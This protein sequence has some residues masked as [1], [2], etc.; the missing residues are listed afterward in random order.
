MD[1]W[2]AH[3]MRRRACVECTHGI[4]PGDRVAIGQWKRTYPWGTRT[5]RVV[6]HWKCWLVKQEIW[7][8]EHPYT[9]VIQ[10]GPGRPVKYTPEQR[11][12]RASLR[13]MINQNKK[14]QVEYIGDDMWATAERY[15][16]KIRVYRDELND[17]R[18]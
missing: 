18:T 15:T 1:L 2:V 8:D 4:E 7:F 9:P 10:A 3:A 13:V 16:D 11:K 12:R 17:M 5:R 6:A 14:K